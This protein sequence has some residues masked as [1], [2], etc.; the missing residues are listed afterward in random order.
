MSLM[1]IDYSR[2]PRNWL[3]EIRPRILKRAGQT[4]TEHA[5]CE[6]CGAVNR[7]PHPITG[8]EVVLTV[9]HLDHDIQN[10]SDDNLMALCQRCHNTLDIWDRIRN[11]RRREREE[12]EAAG[13]G[14]LF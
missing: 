3:T 4:V 10:N 9:A 13:Q 14:V 6:E 8:S 12:K 5:H 11:R 2:Y 1:P 7:S